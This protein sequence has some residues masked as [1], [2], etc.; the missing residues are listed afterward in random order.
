MTFYDSVSHAPAA[1]LHRAQLFTDQRDM[2]V[3]VVTP[4][5]CGT[6]RFFFH[7]F[8]IILFIKIRNGG[9]KTNTKIHHFTYNLE[10]IQCNK[11]LHADHHTV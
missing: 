6:E 4:F 7:F 3:E 8:S 5:L 2:Q 11:K 1:T 10:S 9:G